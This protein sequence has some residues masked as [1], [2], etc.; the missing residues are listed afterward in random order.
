M[1]VAKAIMSNE[2]S[3]QGDDLLEWHIKWALHLVNGMRENAGA[4]DRGTHDEF[5][6]TVLKA[7]GRPADVRDGSVLRGFEGVPRRKG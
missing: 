1:S 7:L 2:K 5:R 4:I 6:E 3:V